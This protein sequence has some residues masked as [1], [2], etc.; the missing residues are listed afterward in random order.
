MSVPSIKEE[1]VQPISLPGHSVESDIS[2]PENQPSKQATPPPP[3]NGGSV[4]WLQVVGAFFLFFNSWGVVNTF[5]VF[6]SYYE[7]ILLLKYSAS[8]ISWIGT[9]QGFLLLMAG[10]IVGPIF[11]KGHLRPLLLL[12]TFLVVFGLMMTSLSTKYYQVFLAQGLVVGVGCAFLFLPSVAVVA[13]YF[14]SRRALATGITAAGGSIGSVIYPIIFHKLIDRLGFGWTTR[15]IAFIALGT[16]CVSVA[17]MKSRLP[18][19]KQ[20]RSMLDPSALKEP[21]FV[22]FS[23]GLFFSFTGLY[24]PFFYLPTYFTTFL[25]SNSNIAFYTIAILNAASVFGRIA[26]GLIADRIG[27]LNTA[28]PITFMAAVLAFA[29]IGIRNEPG[30]IVFACLYGFASGATVSLPPTILARLTPD[31]SVVGTR[32]GMCFAFAALGLL[33]GNPIAGALLNLEHAIFWKAQLFSA[34]MVGVGTLFFA[35]LRILKWKQEAVWKF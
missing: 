24:F 30:T 2:E 19:P 11:D 32:M 8:S 3:P 34:L 35:V 1:S 27:S 5:G 12:G 23:L 6:Q 21:P 33:I 20:S 9:V 10:I 7:D 14:T 4:A 17:V 15:I 22:I 28:L 13:T 26:P 31:M 18:P 25:H 29:W 16:L